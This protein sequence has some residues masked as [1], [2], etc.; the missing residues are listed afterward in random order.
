MS[1]VKLGWSALTIP[2]KI[3]KANSVRTTMAVNAD[4]YV[5]PDP[6]L[7][8]IEAAVGALADAQSEAIKGG[9]DRTITR[10]A[11]L[12]ELTELMNKLVDYVQLTSGGIDENIAKAGMEVRK[13]RE[14]W[15]VPERVSGLEAVPGGNPGTILLTWE[16][17]R[18]RKQYV[19]EMFV[20]GGTTPPDD[21]LDPGAGSDSGAWE[22]LTI[23]G[24]RSYLAVGLQQGKLYRFRVAGINSTGMGDYSE[25]ATSVAS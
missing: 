13:P 1:K 3:V 24:K 21:P 5:T 16:A 14:P 6:P 19:V 18:Y 22:V 8:D 12:S 17:A 25:E 20:E 2:Q 23:T 15:P 9:T 7:A 4:V 11:R 10:N